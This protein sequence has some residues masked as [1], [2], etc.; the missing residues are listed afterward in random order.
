[1]QNPDWPFVILTKV[2]H[3]VTEREREREVDAGMAETKAETTYTKEGSKLGLDR[4]C[5]Q[6]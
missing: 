6:D 1:M 2:K 5:K 4:Q 3:G